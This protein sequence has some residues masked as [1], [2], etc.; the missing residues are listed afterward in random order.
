MHACIHTYIRSIF[1][2]SCLTGAYQPYRALAGQLRVLFARWRLLGDS[3]HKP[4]RRGA[5]Y[6]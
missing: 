3:M 4:Q 6:A 1:L 2:Q 5:D